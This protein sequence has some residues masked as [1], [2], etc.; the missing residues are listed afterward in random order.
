M[1]LGKTNVLVVGKGGR[2]HTIEKTL[3]ASNDVGRVYCAPGNGGTANNVRIDPSDS[4]SLIRFARSHDCVTVV[5][6]EGPLANCIVNDFGKAG[7]PILGPTVE[8]ARLESSKSFAKWFM[9]RNGIPT[10]PF[11][12]FDDP[13]AAIAYAKSRSEIVIKADGLC[14]GKGVAVCDTSR[15]SIG[16]INEMMVQRKFGSAGARIV[17]E[18]RLHG[19][20]ASYIV[21]TDGKSYIPFATSQD[22]KRRNEGDKG[23]NTGG[24]GAY[25]PAAIVTPDL[26]SSIRGRIVEPTI[27]AMA[28]EGSPVVG[29]L[30][31][32]VM[33]TQSPNGPEPQ[34]LEYNVRLGDPEAQAILPRLK[35]DLFPYLNAAIEGRLGNFIDMMWDPRSAVTVVMAANGYPDRGSYGEP[36]QITEDPDPNS[37]IFHSGTKRKNGKLFTDGGRILSVTALGPDLEQAAANAYKRVK[38][39]THPRLHYRRDIASKG[40]DL[41]RR[42]DRLRIMPDPAAEQ[43]AA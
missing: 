23:D 26:E 6:P 30:Y 12:V 29:F 1:A 3:A 28:A 2:E 11:E 27:R 40:I 20:E 4:D 18:E 21:L 41:L 39:V 8:A 7:L 15:E 9:R 17:A 34:L 32:G 13:K 22:H 42:E 24:M 35:S 43:A 16:A 38:T 5:G 25:S 10:A 14:S 19:D 36:L 33:I 31:F 37:F